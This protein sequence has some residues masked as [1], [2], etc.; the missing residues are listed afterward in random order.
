MGNDIAENGAERRISER[1]DE[2]DAEKDPAYF[3]ALVASLKDRLRESDE[4]ALAAPQIGSM[5]RVFALKFAGGDIR[6]FANPLVVGKSGVVM[7]EERQIGESG[8]RWIAPRFNEVEVVYSTPL[9]N[10]EKGTFKGS[11]AVIMQQMIDLLDGVTLEDF[12][13]EV[14]DGWDDLPANEKAE[15]FRLYLKSVERREAEAEKAVGSDAVAK[16]IDGS[17]EFVKAY[18]RKEIETMPL[19]EEE[20]AELEAKTKAEAVERAKAELGKGAG[21]GAK[22]HEA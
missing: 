16:F 8:K 22:A 12:A 17:A 3:D 2:I 20:R 21:D 10:V 6:A 15:V 11:A 7:S 5:D 19:T 1:C 18:Y 14:L 9:G 4:V 13:L